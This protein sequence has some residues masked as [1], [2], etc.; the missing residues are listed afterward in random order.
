MKRLLIVMVF[1]LTL[2]LK[3]S[4]AWYHSFEYDY[5]TA[6][7][8]EATY[9]AEFAGEQLNLSSIEEFLKHYELGALSGRLADISLQTADISGNVYGAVLLHHPDTECSHDYL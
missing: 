8:M 4:A 6:A 7:M 5:T 1:L 2:P 3:G 9:L